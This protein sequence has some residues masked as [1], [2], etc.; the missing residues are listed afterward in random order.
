MSASGLAA[1][2][3]LLLA[4]CA[5]PPPSAYVN[6]ADSGSATGIPL[7]KNA[8]G[9]ACTAQTHGDGPSRIA[10]VYCGTW[11]QPSGSV[12]S[13]GP[14]DASSLLEL[15]TSSG[16]RQA[17]EQRFACGQPTLTT[18]LD[19]VQA[20]VLSCTRRQGGWPHVAFVAAAGGGVSGHDG[21][22]ADGVLPALPA[23]E[24]A[25]AVQSGREK[26]DSAPV[27]QSSAADA[28]LASR[29]A[30][31]AFSSGDIGQ[32]DTL[33]TAGSRANQAE[34][35]A[36]AESAFRAAL[37]LQEKSLG[38]GNPNTATTLERLALQVSNQG[39]F[40]EADTLF[41][42][43]TTLAARS[44]DPLAAPRLQH[45]LALHLIN[46][47][48]VEPALADLETAERGYS[49]LLPPQVLNAHPIRLAS[50]N[51][52]GEA[53]ANREL[54]AEPTVRAALIGTIE[55]RRYRA[56]VLR[57]LGREADADAALASAR[58]LSAG[59][60]L[61]E[62]LEQGR[63]TRTAGADEQFKGQDAAAAASFEAAATSFG[64]VLPRSRPL[65]ETLL[66]QAGAIGSKTGLKGA[67]AACQEGIRILREESIGVT[68]TVVAPCLNIFD[69]AATADPAHRQELLGTMFE[70]AQLAQGGV[71]GTQ[72]AQATARLAEGARDP[73]VAEAI[74]RRQ[75]AGANLT[76]LERD[77]DDRT[78]A[79]AAS[80]SQADL[81]DLDDKVA[82]A[83]TALADADAA[84]QAASPNYG[85][86][87]QEVV[88]AADVF[89][90]LQP[91][92]VFIAVDLSDTG[93]WTFAL[94]NG[95]IKAARITADAPAMAKL[96]QRIRAGVEPTTD[97]LPAFDT[98]AAYKIYQATLAGVA[99][100]LADV[101]SI[102]VAP[103]G[104]LLSVPF[105]ILLTEPTAPDK[106]AGA[107]WLLRR[108]TIAHVP[109]AAN[110]VSL[111]KI[112]G[113]SHATEPWFGFG[114][115]HPVTLAQAEKSFPGA[116]CADSAKLFASL[117]PLPFAGKELEAARQLLGG[118]PQDELLG[119]AFTADAVMKAKLK[120]YRILHFATHALLPAE[121][122]CQSE[123]AIITS[124][125]L[126]AVDASGALLTVSDVV[127][128]DLDADTV[129]LS[130]CN[131]GGG[132]VGESDPKNPAKVSGESL[133]GLARA[134]FYAGARSLMVTHWSVNDQTAAYLVADSMRRV[135]GGD[136]IN[137]ALREAQLSMLDGAG[138]TFPA[139]LA[140][141]FYWGPFA[142]IG[143]GGVNKV[144]SAS[145][146]SPG[147]PNL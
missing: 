71:T 147:K 103:T 85:Q 104:P 140:H 78:Q 143:D 112:A 34:R 42:R 41:A 75:D 144:S 137:Q 119:T 12:H 59:N 135:H 16:W 36:A 60:S 107:P 54:I 10:D 14:V 92:E 82:A 8:A 23:I 58:A 123:A 120:N 1:A 68:P 146:A 88:P 106:L 117:P 138:T 70:A 81:K 114:D 27:A 91:G 125:P 49:A 61:R 44:D 17:I 20:A 84:L 87:V 130:A 6:N 35:F 55:V 69:V 126:K 133:S 131:S 97:A 63:L 2:L 5:V 62:P 53:L 141:P 136:G 77:R 113:N 13:A 102:V 145:L 37:A 4:G 73:K 74:R 46:Q 108:A 19:G 98:D 25:V 26:A 29:L 118:R 67:L 89:A 72:I 95:E 15:A 64:S 94:R 31:Q 83:R 105:G 66:L 32:Y 52:F 116:S 79:A 45:Y 21:W 39:R 142:L 7:G 50:A 121:L 33:M 38:A 40:A 96:V 30:A 93:G 128:L 111:R 28:L 3:A 18:I 90:L 127:G 129:I 48:K 65:A 109:A 86:L 115:F 43:A 99:S 139:A 56:V 57:D 51:G 22:Y 101:K 24:R 124:A 9:E 76:T 122:R 134:F 11:Q 80:G 110:F 47:G 132:S 100:D